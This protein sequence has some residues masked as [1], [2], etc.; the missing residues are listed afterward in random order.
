MGKASS[1]KKVA[2][3]ARAGGSRRPGQRRPIGFPLVVVLVCVV[4]VTL[5]LYAR[6]Q[7][8]ANAA[9]RAGEDH[10]HAAYTI[11]ECDEF[12][13]ALSGATQ[14]RL[15]IHTHDDGLIHVEPLLDG[16]AGVNARLQLFVDYAG[17]TLSD[18][19]ASFPDGTTWDEA[20]SEC[21]GAPAQIVI[22]RWIDAQ[23]AADGE[24][25][26]EVVTENFDDIRFKND[27]EA[28]TIAL[29]PEGTPEA[30]PVR[31]DIV[32]ELNDAT[33]TPPAPTTTVGSTSLSEPSL[34]EPSSTSGPP[35]PAVPGN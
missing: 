5:V 21:D 1:A 14:D 31:P 9:P 8:Q 20:T 16:A 22:A 30:I 15:G 33:D 13:P 24:K 28:Y 10:W 25:P 17:V 4:G 19:T 27:R 32:A 7:R 11:A 35:A 26:N 34:S 2:R 29:V 3:A 6:N 12:E 23:D 18:D